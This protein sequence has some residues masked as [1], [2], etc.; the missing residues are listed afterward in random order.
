MPA[1]CSSVPRPRDSL[2]FLKKKRSA[3]GGGTIRARPADA[4]PARSS[5]PH[6]TSAHARKEESYAHSAHSS[7][8]D[9]STH[10]RGYFLPLSSAGIAQK[11]R[12]ADSSS[13]KRQGL[14]FSFFSAPLSS[15]ARGGGRLLSRMAS[16][17]FR[18]RLISSLFSA[19]PPSHIGMEWKRSSQVGS[20]VCDLICCCA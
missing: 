12:P 8:I 15:C 18:H 10:E 1:A 11:T 4:A 5:V 6:S 7:L 13:V 17:C 2:F 14:F 19:P 20:S 3:G 9:P 16:S